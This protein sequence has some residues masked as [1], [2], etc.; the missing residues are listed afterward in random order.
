MAGFS[1]RHLYVFFCSDNPLFSV[2]YLFACQASNGSNPLHGLGWTTFWSGCSSPKGMGMGRWLENQ[3]FWWLSCG[4]SRLVVQVQFL[5]VL[6]L[7][8]ILLF[9]LELWKAKV[10]RKSWCKRF[11]SSTPLEQYEI[12]CWQAFMTKFKELFAFIHLHLSAWK[13]RNLPRSFF[14][15][16]VCVFV[17]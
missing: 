11:C 8:F 7:Y 3:N 10:E 13:K 15:F 14:L 5:W 4:W 16:S 6:K 17:F 1:R 2:S 12:D 9:Q